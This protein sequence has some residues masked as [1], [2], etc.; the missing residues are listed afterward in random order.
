MAACGEDAVAATG[1]VAAAAAWWRQCSSMVAK[2]N[3]IISHA[4]S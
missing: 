1:E 3:I 2:Q 4:I